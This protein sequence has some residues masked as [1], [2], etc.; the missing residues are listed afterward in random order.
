MDEINKIRKD[1]FVH[2]EKKHEIAKKYQRS[3]AT[4][5]RV[6][7]KTREELEQPS[8][9]PNR[10]CQ[11]ITP[12][13]IK[14]IEA[15]LDEEVELKV[16]RKQRYTTQKI[17]DDLKSKGIYKGAIRRL[18]DIINRLRKDR[19][20]SKKKVFLPLTF[21]LGSTIQIDHGEVDL[22]V[23]ESRKKGYLFV[24]SVPGYCLRFCQ[25]FPIKSQEA[26]GEFHER[27]FAFFGGIF[28]KV[29]YDN[30]SVLIKE[31]IGNERKQTSFSL[32]LEE[33]FGIN[34]HFCNVASGHEKGSVENAV[35]YCRRN[36][37]AGCRSFSDWES[38]NQQL[39]EF[40]YQEIE[41][42]SHYKTARSLKEIYSEMQ[43]KL[44][45]LPKSQQWSKSS[46]CKVNSYQLVT[47]DHHQYSVPQKYVGAFIRVRLSVF[48]VTIFHKEELIAKYQRQYE[49]RDSLLLDHYLDQL[50]YKPA[51]FSDCTA[52]VQNRFPDSLAC[53]RQKLLDKQ[54]KSEADREFVRLL[55]LGRKYP[56]E[57]LLQA[58][59]ES[60]KIGI[61]HYSVVEN[62]LYRKHVS[63]QLNI[64]QELSGLTV[65]NISTW[66]FDLSQYNELLEKAL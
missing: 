43:Q 33:H 19:G 65:V 7:S 48:E 24:G 45:P 20:Q 23:N 4:I 34:S 60:I 40:C 52:V 13:V 15:Y 41:Q 9:R 2:E 50:E 31:V 6:V 30:D 10:K 62:L 61:V 5:N 42:G 12:E 35:G 46:D 32:S 44:L 18:H 39:T 3:W 47:I 51:A 11:V 58:V 66:D 53:F 16:K 26:W 55:L 29:V 25:I 27:V 49:N 64:R 56:Q 59:E 36:F 17:Y 57:E 54:P 14:V 37:F 21:E 22:I 1:F 63:H 28:K 8:S 38:I